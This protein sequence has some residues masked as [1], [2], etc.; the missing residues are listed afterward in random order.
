MQILIAFQITV[1][2]NYKT[3]EKNQIEAR[4][5]QTLFI[6]LENKKKPKELLLHAKTVIL[7]LI[8]VVYV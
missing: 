8:I 2:E 6:L 5:L 1:A 3:V 4:R 7:D